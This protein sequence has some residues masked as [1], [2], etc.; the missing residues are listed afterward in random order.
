MSDKEM[1]N[2]FIQDKADEK[3]QITAQFIERIAELEKQLFEVKEDIKAVKQDAKDEGIE[4]AK[5]MK[6]YNAI[7]R[8]LKRDPAKLAED[9]EY[10]KLLS[11]S[12]EMFSKIREVV[13]YEKR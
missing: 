1:I 13:E 12:I 8:Q 11:S 2:Q 10:S 3:T 6:A 9:E 5:V 7:K 4:V